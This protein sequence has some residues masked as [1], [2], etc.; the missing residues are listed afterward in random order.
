[1]A[2]MDCLSNCSS[3]S[4][5]QAYICIVNGDSHMLFSNK[6]EKPVQAHKRTTALQMHSCTCG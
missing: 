1:M 5:Q 6:E 4:K 3:S 2:N